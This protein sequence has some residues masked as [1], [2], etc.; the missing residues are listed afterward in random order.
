MCVDTHRKQN[1]PPH[2]HKT[3][4]HKSNKKDTCGVYFV[5]ASY[6]WASSLAWAV[7]AVCGD[8]P[9]ESTGCPFLAGIGCE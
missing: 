1:T 9:L 7:V 4:K 6:S 2:T 5:L 3:P 8:I